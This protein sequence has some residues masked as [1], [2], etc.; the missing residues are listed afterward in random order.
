MS[1]SMKFEIQISAEDP[2]MTVRIQMLMLV[3]I[4]I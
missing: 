3:A 2:Q 4:K 1:Q